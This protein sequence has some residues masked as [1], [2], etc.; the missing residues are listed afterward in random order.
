MSPEFQVST[1][2]R[3]TSTFSSDI[4]HAVSLD[5]PLLSMQSSGLR[6]LA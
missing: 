2:A 3:T 5:G 4:A 1:R 6:K